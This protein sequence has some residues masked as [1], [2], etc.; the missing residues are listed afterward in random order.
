[1]AASGRIDATA[2]LT[3][4]KGAGRFRSAEY[5]SRQ[6]DTSRR[7][8]LPTGNLSLLGQEVTIVRLR[9]PKGLLRFHDSTLVDL[10]Q[11]SEKSSGFSN[12]WT[13]DSIS[14]AQAFGRKPNALPALCNCLR[15]KSL[16]PRARFEL[17]T[18][19]LTA[20]RPT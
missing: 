19:R 5:P 20:L 18:L 6:R 15:P 2:A 1:M 3:V 4:P 11:A 17:A 9:N 10:G 13:V 14:H 8:T 12:S 7:V 16:A